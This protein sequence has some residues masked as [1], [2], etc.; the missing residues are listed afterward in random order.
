MPR[1]DVDARLVLAMCGAPPSVDPST[2]LPRKA[3]ELAYP[4]P[5]LFPLPTEHALLAGPVGFAQG[6]AA[7]SGP[8]ER[9]EHSTAHTKIPPGVIDFAV[10]NLPVRFSRTAC[11]TIDVSHWVIRTMFP[12]RWIRCLICAAL[13]SPAGV[14]AA[15][16]ELAGV[17]GTVSAPQTPSFPEPATL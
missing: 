2:S 10:R 16:V 9:G 6:C 3:T 1:F 5:A 14:L 17:F 15:E 13:A 7:H 4:P 11:A 12:S 8:R